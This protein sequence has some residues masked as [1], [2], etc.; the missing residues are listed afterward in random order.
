MAPRHDDNG[1]TLPALD[2]RVEELE[3]RMN[4]GARSEELNAKLIEH[5]VIPDPEAADDDDGE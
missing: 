5:G 2:A 3:R 1:V 4:G